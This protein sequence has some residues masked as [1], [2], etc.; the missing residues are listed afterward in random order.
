MGVIG[1]RPG[2]PGKPALSAL[3]PHPTRGHC[4]PFQCH[5]TEMPSPPDDQPARSASAN[6][7]LDLASS[8]PISNEA[9]E[10]TL[11]HFRTENLKFLPFMHI[12][13][14][15]TSYQFRQ[16]KPF[17]WLCIMAVSYPGYH[18]KRDV[19]VSKITELIHTELMVEV[20]PSMD[21]LLGI[22]TAITWV[23]YSK[24]PFLNF[25][26]HMLMGIA[27]DLGINKAISKDQS[28]MQQF[29]SAVGMRYPHSTVRTLEERRAAL[30]VFLIT[31][32]TALCLG[33]IDALRW[34]SHMEESLTVL[35]K[36]KECPEDELLVYLVKIQLV[37]DK[38]YHAR[39]DGEDQ[40][41]ARFYITSSQAQL[42]SVRSQIPPHLINTIPIIL[43]LNSAELIIHETAMQAPSIPNSPQLNRLESLYTCLQADKAWMDCW[44]SIPP[45]T[46]QGIPF[47][48]FFQFSRALVSLYK[49]STLDDPAWDKQMV[50]NTINV[51][52]VLD[53]NAFNMK[54]CA[55]MIDIDL[56]PDWSIFEKGCRM[57]ASIKQSWEPKLMEV[58]Y[59]TIPPK[60]LTAV[61][62][63]PGPSFLVRY[64]CLVSM[65]HG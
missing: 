59:P 24:R 32:S 58:W 40:S 62:F 29:K 15:Y 28:I 31:S 36:A 12:P 45:A 56:D 26:C 55:E 43:H 35:L 53:R 2:V 64:P 6:R 22:I 14:H 13:S 61:S 63:H 44:L 5:S 41:L 9:A 11:A 7:L 47:N 18:S 20:A 49:L 48:I 57:I 17:T 25:Y 34:T 21:M 33:R 3:P 1:V 19:L 27:C 16:E 42:N 46:Y 4:S 51:L 60:G 8:L 39:R 30:G 10:K 50:R 54:R 38:V 52:D 23:T 65:M 37:M